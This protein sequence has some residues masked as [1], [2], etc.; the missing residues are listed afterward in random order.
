MNPKYP[1]RHWT[2]TQRIALVFVIILAVLASAAGLFVYIDMQENSSVA[3]QGKSQVVAQAVS[4]ENKR[5]VVDHPLFTMELPQDW[6]EIS[7]QNISL[8][9]SITWQA[10]KKNYENRMLTLY[11]DRIPPNLAVNKIMTVEVQSNQLAVGDVSDNCVNFTSG[12]AMNPAAGTGYDKPAKWGGVDFICEM[13]ST[14]DNQIGVGSKSGMNQIAVTG[15]KGLHKYFF[16]Y[17]DRNIQ[18]DNS[19]LRDALG[20]FKAK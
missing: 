15:T 2:K 14:I 7:R 6:K 12:G 1:H 19:I 11:I 5:L 3:V 16:I 8:E 13:G 17:T 18:P 4:P 10:T 9:Q 20:S